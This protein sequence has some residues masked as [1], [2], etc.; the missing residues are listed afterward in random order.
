V[1]T[2]ALIPARGGSKGVPRK[3]VRELAGKPLVAWTI[4]S[5][6]ACVGVDRIVVSTDDEQIG[7]ICRESGAEVPFLR[8]AELALDDTPDRP[9]YDHAVEWLAEHADYR[10][11]AVVWLRPT[12]PL[13]QPQDI[14]AGLGVLAETGCDSVRS[15]CPV[16]HHPYWMRTLEGDRLRRLLPEAGEEAFY[17]RQLLPDVYRLNGAV[18]IVRCSSV[19][20]TPGLFGGDVRA[21]VMPLERS[22]DIDSETDF[23][24]A[25]LLLDRRKR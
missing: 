19:A 22:V 20:K 25:E 24:L 15:V 2:L 10:P 9:V 21:Y 3:N 8:P 1:N 13:R 11:D 7:D 17:Q 23:T 16:E 18:D 5:A 12:A 6:R 4:E 14:D